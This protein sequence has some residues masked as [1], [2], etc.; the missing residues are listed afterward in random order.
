MHT[1]PIGTT[2]KVLL[3]LFSRLSIIFTWKSL[4]AQVHSYYDAVFLVQ[5]KK[6]AIKTKST[7]S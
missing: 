5:L 6:V 2:P 4:S 3:Q 7:H 1:F